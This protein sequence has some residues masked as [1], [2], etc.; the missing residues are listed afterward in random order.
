MPNYNSVQPVTKQDSGF[1]LSEWVTPI[2]SGPYQNAVIRTE[3]HE[4][5]DIDLI[6]DLLADEAL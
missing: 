2:L 4:S 5:D 1:P 6:V 3:Q